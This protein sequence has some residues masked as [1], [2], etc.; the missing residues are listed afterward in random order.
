MMND[1]QEQR[2]QTAIRLPESSLKL[3]DKIADRMSRG[4]FATTRAEVL[5]AAVAEGLKKLEGKKR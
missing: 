5:R 4:G 3:A 2:I 1:K